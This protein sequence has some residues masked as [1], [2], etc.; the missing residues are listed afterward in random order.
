MEELRKKEGKEIKGGRSR[1][2]RERERKKESKDDDK[3]K[4]V[5][6]Y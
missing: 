5:L 4:I 6:P 1:Q 2:S 3:N